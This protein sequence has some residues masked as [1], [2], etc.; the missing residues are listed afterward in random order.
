MDLN[1]QSV[2]MQGCVRCMQRFAATV[3]SRSASG[4]SAELFVL[5]LNMQQQ[6]VA[7]V[8]LSIGSFAS[9]GKSPE[10]GL[11]GPGVYR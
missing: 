9:I 7:G 10:M 11:L 1:L 8:S 5:V 2:A 6:A 4:V 3:S